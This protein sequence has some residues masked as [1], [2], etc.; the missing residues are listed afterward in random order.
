MLIYLIFRSIS[1]RI[2][3]KNNGAKDMFNNL[4]N[5]SKSEFKHLPWRKNRT[6]FRTLVSEFM[7]QQ[8]TVT[9]VLKHFDRFVELYPDIETLS[10]ATEEE[11]LVSWKGLGYYRR[12]KNL[13]KAA[14]DINIFFEN[15]IPTLYE[16]L[17][18]ISGIGDYTANALLS[19]GNGKGGYAIDAN[20]ERVLSRLFL[21]EEFKGKDLHHKIKN[22]KRIQ[23]YLETNSPRDLNEAIMDLGRIYCK[24]NKIYCEA[25]PMSEHCKSFKLGTS[26]NYPNI[27]KKKSVEK[28]ELLLLRIIVKDQGKLLVYKKSHNEWLAGQW[29]LPTFTLMTTDKKLDQY[30]CGLELKL[31]KFNCDLLADFKSSITK[32]SI[33]N[34]IIEMEYSDFVKLLGD[35]GHYQLKSYPK[36]YDHLGSTCQKALS[37]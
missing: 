7:L 18:Q 6:L 17:I 29:E 27:K 31:D 21:L 14:I 15:T 20:I 26:L 19:I 16:E 30:P 4:I 25:C 8:T 12:A 33:M 35:S 32:Y 22:N 11:I 36:I 28:H 5:W 24:A 13:R 23:S 2:A 1:L 3:I 9:A 37:N 34:N 10:T